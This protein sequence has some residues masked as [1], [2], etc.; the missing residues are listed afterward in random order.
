MPVRRTNVRVEGGQL[1][2]AFREPRIRRI[3]VLPIAH[4]VF[5]ERRGSENVL[6]LFRRVLETHAEIVQLIADTENAH[7]Q[8]SE[9]LVG[10]SD[11]EDLGLRTRGNGG[12]PGGRRGESSKNKQENGE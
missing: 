10:G 1:V 9:V 3:F 12:Q 5:D 11:A 7:L 2:D 6:T 8:P 4:C